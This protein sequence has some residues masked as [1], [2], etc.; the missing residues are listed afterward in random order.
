MGIVFQAFGYEDCIF[1]YL[2]WICGQ[3]AHR[4]AREDFG[5][6]RNGCIR[7]DKLNKHIA[8]IKSQRETTAFMSPRPSAS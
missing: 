1:I 2:F 8:Q 3:D 4:L 5:K 6:P 7:I